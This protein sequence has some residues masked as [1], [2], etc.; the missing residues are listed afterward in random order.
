MSPKEQ[1]TYI[2]RLGQL[3]YCWQFITLAGL[4]SNALISHSFAKAFSQTGMRAYGNMIQEPE[5]TQ[6][7][8]VLTHQ[9][10]SGANYVDDML[11]ML[12]GGVSSTSAMGEGVTEKQ[13]TEDVG[14]EA[15]TAGG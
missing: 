14:D 4:H 5:A 11:R 1:E 3:G 12:T 15:R 13:F 10:W 9:A 6:G 8:P 7:V 2:A